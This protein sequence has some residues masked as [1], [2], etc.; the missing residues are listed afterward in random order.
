MRRAGVYMSVLLLV[1]IPNFTGKIIG[2]DRGRSKACR[3]GVVHCTAVYFS[4]FAL[5]S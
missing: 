2:W 5:Y 3:I 4:V 1:W